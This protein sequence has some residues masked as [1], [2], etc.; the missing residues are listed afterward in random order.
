M[1]STSFAASLLSALAAL[2]VLA[3]PGRAAPAAADT[4]YE[5]KI[6]TM[7][8]AKT[9]WDEL[10]R[11][12]KKAVESAS[13]KR[14]KV[15]IFNGGTL[16]DEN[17]TVRMLTRGQIQ[18]VGA[19]TGAFASVVKELDAL[20]IPY[21]FDNVKVA[22]FVLD[23]YLKDPVD[24]LFRANGMV[25]GF[26][27]ENG[28][29][30]F[31]SKWGAV[32]SP[33]DLKGRKVRSQENATHIEM[34]KALGASLQTIPTPDVATALRTDAVEGFDQSIMMTSAASWAG[35]IKYYTLSGHI[36]QPAAIAYNQAWFDG[37]PADLQQI[38]VTE[39]D[40]IVRSGRAS[41]RAMNEKIV[42][43]FTK[44]G[45]TVVKLSAEEKAAFKKATAG[46]KG[47]L[48][49]RDAGTAALIDAID[50][51]IKAYK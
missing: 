4:T 43:S 41:V 9:P 5:M 40:K 23:K 33:A 42:K 11:E 49:S 16:G 2:F 47:I 21:T 7:A 48:R 6:A 3:G 44:K 14:I 32:R 1:R 26:W 27:N 28:F 46:V 35:E 10:L 51:G 31:G 22:D 29:R 12:F 25:F 30:H 18:C 45:V 50:R 24:K 34:W 8:P 37:L 17:T 15:K 13:G 20:E 39:G 36:Y 19:S 38:L